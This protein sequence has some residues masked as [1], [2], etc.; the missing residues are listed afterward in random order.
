MEKRQLAAG[1]LDLDITAREDSWISG[2]IC[3]VLD[4]CICLFIAPLN[5]LANRLLWVLISHFAALL[6]A[7][8][9]G[10]CFPIQPS[11]IALRMV[12]LTMN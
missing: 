10:P 12:P 2:G 3:F 6:S 5:K 8:I 9:P 1:A 7:L 11:I 4:L